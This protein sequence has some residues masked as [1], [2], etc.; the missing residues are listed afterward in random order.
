MYIPLKTFVPHASEIWTKSYGPNYT[1]IFSILTKNW[2]F[3]IIFDK[4]L[5]PFWKTFPWLK[6]LLKAKLLISRLPSFRVP[7]ITGVRHV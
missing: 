1:Q 4:A 7:K 6:Q 2:G 3:K 5:T